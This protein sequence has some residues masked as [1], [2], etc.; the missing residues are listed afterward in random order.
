MRAG[1]KLPAEKC[2]R[3]KNYPRKNAHGEEVIS[4]KMRV[5]ARVMREGARVKITR[6]KMRA[7]EKLLAEKCARVK[8]YPRKNVSGRKI[9]CG[10][11]CAD[12]KLPAEKCAWVKITCGKM[13]AGKKLPA[14]KCARVEN[15]LGNRENKPRN[16]RAFPRAL[17]HFRG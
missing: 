7:G 1:E 14:E 16:T 15:T 11:M 3:V 2:A 13:R 4:S 6:G 5:S 10:K 9:T 12:E 8:N 17:A